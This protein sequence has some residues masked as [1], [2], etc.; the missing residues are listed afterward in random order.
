MQ[1]CK[2]Q[3]KSL[4]TNK[5]LAFIFFFSVSQKD[6][7]F[8]IIVYSCRNVQGQNNWLMTIILQGLKCLVDILN[9]KW[10][11]LGNQDYLLCLFSS[12][13]KLSLSLKPDPKPTDTNS[14]LSADIQGNTVHQGHSGNSQSTF[15]YKWNNCSFSSGNPNS[16]LSFSALQLVQEI[17]SL[18]SVKLLVSHRGS[19]K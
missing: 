6:L 2:K 12:L 1:W 11:K 9:S 18:C 19:H 5:V 3:L 14:L 4:L 17:H 10:Q 15:T 8:F 7:F 13:S 16:N